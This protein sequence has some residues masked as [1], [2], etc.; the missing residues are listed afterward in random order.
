MPRRRD[1]DDEDDYRPRRR[2]KIKADNHSRVVIW[3]I[4][5]VA[6]LVALGG[7]AVGV[8]LL[9]GSIAKYGGPQAMPGLVAYWSF[10]DDSEV[11]HVADESRRG[12]DGR[13]VGGRIG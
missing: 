9:R 7:I 8:I 10:N 13:L 4:V 12:N 11:G 3:M 2:R 5:T 1:D 6:I